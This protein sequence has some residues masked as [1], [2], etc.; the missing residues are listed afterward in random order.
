MTAN[1]EMGGHY[2]GLMWQLPPSEQ[3]VGWRRFESSE[4]ESLPR[5]K[6][7][8]GAMWPFGAA[9]L[10]DCA[11]FLNISR[12]RKLVYAILYTVYFRIISLGIMILL[13]A[14]QYHPGD[15]PLDI[16]L[17]TI[18]ILAYR[19]GTALLFPDW[20]LVLHKWRKGLNG[21][22]HCPLVLTLEGTSAPMALTFSS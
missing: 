11:P 15:G 3:W 17:R 9:L 1:F 19:G 8:T 4:P 10:W 21:W 22:I 13:S 6:H 14:R 7:L 2:K 18:L 5:W 20:D 16:L 12:Y